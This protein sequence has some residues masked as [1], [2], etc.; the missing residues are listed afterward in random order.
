MLRQ[1]IFIFG[2]IKYS[3][4]RKQNNLGHIKNFFI[5]LGPPTGPPTM[6]YPVY[7]NQTL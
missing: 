2:L 4:P 3:V 1:H 5:P 6:K 7:L